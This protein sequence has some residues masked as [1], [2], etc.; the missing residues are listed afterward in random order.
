MASQRALMMALATVAAVQA[1]RAGGAHDTAT[2]TATGGGGDALSR[3]LADAHLTRWEPQLRELG[4]AVPADLGYLSVDDLAQLGMKPVEAKRLARMFPE[5]QERHPQRRHLQGR[6]SGSGSGSSGVC[7]TPVADGA[8]I[9]TLAAGMHGFPPVGA[10]DTGAVAV[11]IHFSLADFQI[12]DISPGD[13]EWTVRFHADFYWTQDDCDKSLGNTDACASRQGAFYFASLPDASE[14]KAV[15]ARSLSGLWPVERGTGCVQSDFVDAK[16]TIANSFDLDHYPYEAHR[17]RLKLRS[18]HTTKN[19]ELQLLSEI[20]VGG[21][22]ELSHLAPPGWDADSL[23]C[24]AETESIAD[25]GRG[26][27]E[28]E[29]SVVVCDII[30]SRV[31]SSYFIR[32]L[33]Y[34]SCI[35]IV[36]CVQ[37]LRAVKTSELGKRAVPKRGRR[38]P[39]HLVASWVTEPLF[40]RGRTSLG[41]TLSFAF[42]LKSSP[43]D[44]DIDYWASGAP[45]SSKLYCI[46][47]FFLLFSAFESLALGLFSVAFL[48]DRRLQPKWYWVFSHRLTF[49]EDAFVKESAGIAEKKKAG[50][51]TQV[52][53]VALRPADAEEVSLAHD[54]DSPSCSPLPP[55]RDSPRPPEPTASALTAVLSKFADPMIKPHEQNAT[56]LQ[57]VK[58]ARVDAVLWLLLHAVLLFVVVGML[59]NARAAY[60]SRM[61][62][63]AAHGF[64]R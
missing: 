38:L 24:H 8:R 43:Y 9:Q 20:D 17:L 64:H 44:R 62:G 60:S 48:R 37:G 12:Q 51:G 31:H 23:Y 6:G 14:E 49:V 63:D 30:V 22:D 53:Q 40:A 54:G 28:L 16:A 13:S 2:D 41:F 29:Y 56:A 34:M 58:L 32:D 61:D 26:T 50:G 19:V 45:M 47:L 11:S 33:M 5:E 4:C 55:I 21:T 46:G 52:E 25:P 36:N 7:T 57:M 1:V 27:T 39:M 35:I 59:W 10:F 18:F 3:A 15:S 42:V